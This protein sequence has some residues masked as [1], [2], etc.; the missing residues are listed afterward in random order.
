MK[1]SNPTEIMC[2][3]IA[4]FSLL[5]IMLCLIALSVDLHSIYLI[6]LSK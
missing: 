3:S 5:V 2:L 1:D 6:L 4:A